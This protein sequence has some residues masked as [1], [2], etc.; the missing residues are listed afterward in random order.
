[1]E[2]AFAFIAGIVIGMLAAAFATLRMRA[3]VLMIDKT[4]PEKDIYRL[5]IDDLDNVSS[6]DFIILRVDS[7]ADLSQK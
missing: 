6:K 4:N 3:G 2:F 1:M 7:H 5:E